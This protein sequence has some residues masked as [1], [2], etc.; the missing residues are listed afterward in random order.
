MLTTVVSTKNPNSQI[1]LINLSYKTQKFSEAYSMPKKRSLRLTLFSCAGYQVK[2][3]ISHQRHPLIL[4]STIYESPNKERQKYV[5]F[6]HVKVN[7]ILFS[8]TT[9]I[10]KHLEKYLTSV[11]ARRLP[12][13]SPKKLLRLSDQLHH[14]I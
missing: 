3:N 1:K 2:N 9:L 4:S 8:N 7:K 14:L 11:Q 5:A 12:F 10:Y 13:I 6:Y